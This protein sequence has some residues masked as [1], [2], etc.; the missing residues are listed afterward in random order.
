MSEMVNSWVL[1]ELNGQ[2]YGI[3]TEFIQEMVLYGSTSKLPDHPDYVRGVVN[4][5]G[6]VIPIID[7]RKQLGMIGYME[8]RDNLIDIFNK[9]EQDHIVWLNELKSS[10]EENREFTLT[11]DPHACEFGKWYDNYRTENQSLKSLL[12]KM[13]APHRGIH[14]IDIEIKD[15]I[16]NGD[17]RSAVAIVQNA[18]NT[19]L[20]EL[21]SL[22]QETREMLM[23]STREIIIV[24]RLDDFNIGFA[25]DKVEDVLDINPEDI[26]ESPKVKNGESSYFICGL[27][28]VNEDIKILLNM[29][30]L[31]KGS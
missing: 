9:R 8:E 19:E 17:T 26:E 27:A 20:S 24:T 22:F 30:S 11:T 31:V 6:T 25:V 1:L 28:K 14:D 29:E 12:S 15:S 2:Q 23:E 7:M 4:L 18:W 10:I 3:R 16:E 21:R 5:R 13:D